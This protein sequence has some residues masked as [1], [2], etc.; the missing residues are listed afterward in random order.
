MKRELSVKMKGFPE[1]QQTGRRKL[2]T[3]GPFIPRME[4]KLQIYRKLGSHDRSEMSTAIK[5]DLKKVNYPF[6]RLRRSLGEHSLTSLDSGSFTRRMHLVPI[7]DRADTAPSEYSPTQVSTQSNLD[8]WS[9]WTLLAAQR[10]ES[11]LKAGKVP[12]IQHFYTSPKFS[13]SIDESLDISPS[14]HPITG[15]QSYGLESAVGQ[16]VPWYITVLQEKERC[17]LMLGEEINR[18]NK[19]EVECARKNDIIS[20]L[21]EEVEHLQEQLDQLQNGDI[22]RVEDKGPVLEPLGQVELLEVIK[23]QSSTG[24]E[25]EEEEEEAEL[26][27]VKEGSSKQSVSYT[28]G[29]AETELPYLSDSSVRRDSSQ[30]ESEEESLVEPFIL[31]EADF[32]QQMEK[33]KELQTEIDKLQKENQELQ[34][35]MEKNR[36]DYGICSGTITSL[37]RQ[38]FILE[39]KL[40][41]AEAEKEG[42]A[43][44]LKDRAIQLHAMSVKFSNLHDERKHQELLA[45]IEEENYL[46]RQQVSMLK[47]EL[48]ERDR[49]LE[50]SKAEIQRQERQAEDKQLQLK[51]CLRERKEAEN[52]VETLQHLEHKTKV[53]LEYIQSRFERFRS[54]LVQTTYSSPGTKSPTYE[55]N[56]GDILDAMQK[57]IAERLEFQLLLKQNG[58]KVPAPLA[59]EPVVPGSP[60]QSPSK[61]SLGK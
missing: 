21:R 61:K 53:A 6:H 7:P 30:L 51:R 25:E 47:S 32:I 31:D 55:V 28:D 54:K 22:C 39:S 16:K 34:D 35:E 20:I 48:A 41:K 40:R 38:L 14:L 8:R 13:T 59:P 60:R 5:E 36:N 17:L 46:L 18:L 2:Q 50:E 57:I 42:M 24:E 45:Q 26:S 58:I 12:V 56:D 52:Q 11:S 33:E 29:A 19:W 3:P 43:K 1:L 15:V 23:E 27:S 49:Q 9:S 37:Q 4:S 10:S 44:E